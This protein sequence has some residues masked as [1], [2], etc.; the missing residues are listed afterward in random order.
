[1]GSGSDSNIS[2]AHAGHVEL[3]TSSKPVILVRAGKNR[4]KGFDHG[5]LELSFNRLCRP[6][7]RDAF[8]IASRYG[9]SEVITLYASATAIIRESLGW[10]P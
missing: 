10:K 2:T 9:R 1:M 4:F 6:E 3:R 5:R 7:A 8:G